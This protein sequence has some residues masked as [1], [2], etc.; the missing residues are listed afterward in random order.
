MRSLFK[1]FFLGL[2]ILVAAQ[3]N[4]GPV[5]PLTPTPPVIPDEIQWMEL[6]ERGRYDELIDATS[7]AITTSPEAPA[8][9]LFRGDA[10]FAKGDY[11]Q[12]ERDYRQAAKLAPNLAEAYRGLWRVSLVLGRAEEAEKYYERAIELNPDLKAEMDRELPNLLR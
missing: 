8:P 7:G 4:C 6:L 2:T 10:Y 11:R 3:I 9:Y 12:A 1:T 5:P